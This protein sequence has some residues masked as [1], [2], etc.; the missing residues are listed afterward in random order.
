MRIV[1][2]VILGL[3]GF[4]MLA[5]AY[6][7]LAPVDDARWHQPIAQREDTDT[8]T[9]AVRVV[10]GG[11]EMLAA[12]DAAMRALPRTRVLAG[13]VDTGLITYETRSALWGFP[14]YTT[15]DHGD[16]V[17]TLFARLRYGAS[18]LG[19]NAARLANVLG[20]VQR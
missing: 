13:S 16:G 8:R 9:G 10:A 14:D 20:A 17:I 2:Y 19:V 4:A 12:I 1:V 18:D 3:V 5:G 15:V 11:A 6:V 7:R